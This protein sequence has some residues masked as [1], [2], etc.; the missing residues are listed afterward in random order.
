MRGPFLLC[1]ILV[2]TTPTLAQTPASATALRPRCPAESVRQQPSPR[3]DSLAALADRGWW[4][5]EGGD[6]EAGIEQTRAALRGGLRDPLVYYN[7]GIALFLRQRPNDALAALKEAAQLWPEC[8]WPWERTADILKYLGRT[9][10]AE[11]ARQK[12]RSRAP[13]RPF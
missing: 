12:A 6:L 13:G 10:D 2:S 8:A 4:N 9:A 5:L 7:F 11:D 1:L 3:L